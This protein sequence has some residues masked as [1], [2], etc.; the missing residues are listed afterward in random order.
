MNEKEEDI[1][2]GQEPSKYV[3]CNPRSTAAFPRII[4]PVL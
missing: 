1:I 3:S 4:P 2:G